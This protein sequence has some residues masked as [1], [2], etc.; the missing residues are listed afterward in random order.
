MAYM[1]TQSTMDARRARNKRDGPTYACNV[2]ELASGRGYHPDNPVQEGGIVYQKNR[3][4]RDTGVDFSELWRVKL[5]GGE[6]ERKIK[7]VKVKMARRKQFNDPKLGSFRSLTEVKRWIDAY[8]ST[9]ERS[10]LRGFFTRHIPNLWTLS[11]DGS[12]DESSRL[13]ELWRYMKKH[14]LLR[15]MR[16]PSEIRFCYINR[17][18]HA[19]KDLEMFELEMGAGVKSMTEED[20]RQ[21]AASRRDV[22]PMADREEQVFK[23][24]KRKRAAEGVAA[25]SSKRSKMQE[26]WDAPVPAVVRSSKAAMNKLFMFSK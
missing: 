6:A 17:K 14:D 24:S 7:L 1:P 23:G 8:T 20:L 13:G 19:R 12:M 9:K 2:R 3:H 26:L 4:I 11:S 5:G 21:C 22:Q 15:E 10:K 18:A 16:F 25:S